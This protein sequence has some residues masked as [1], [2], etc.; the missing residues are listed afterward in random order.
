[1]S[2][3]VL[4]IL[5]L[6]RSEE[7]RVG[8]ERRSRGSPT[9]Y[10]IDEP[11]TGLHFADIEKLLSILRSLVNRGNTV[12]V[13]EHNLDVVGSCDYVIELGPEGGD[14]GGEAIFEGRI[15]DLLGKN[16]PTAQSL[17]EYRE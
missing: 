16:T 12:V 3:K 4:N 17:K 15:A 10:K 8:K 11:T 6:K 2:P 13:I 7:R 14:K 5:D 9:H 1:M